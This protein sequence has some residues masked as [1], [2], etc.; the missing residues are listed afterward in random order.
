[1]KLKKKEYKLIEEFTKK[2]TK[3]L[4]KARKEYGMNYMKLNK[5]KTMDEI[6]EELLDIVGWGLMFWMKL[7]RKGVI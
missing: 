2:L 5:K 4:E 3:K 1:M 7:K 6:E